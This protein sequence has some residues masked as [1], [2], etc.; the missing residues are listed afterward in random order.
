MKSAD[1]VP[2]L[3]VRPDA[4]KPVLRVDVF[5]TRQG[6]MDGL[7]DDPDNTKS[8]FWHH[9][10]TR[11]QGDAWLAKLPLSGT[12]KPI[13][14]YANVVYPLD[15]PVSGAGYYYRLYQ[16][17][18]FNL[19]SLMQMATP[20]E[21]KAAG[22][23]ATIPPSLLIE[24]FEGDWEK[25][26]FNYK[27]N[28]WTLNT[29]KLY[30]DPWKAPEGAR[31]AIEVLS[32]SPNKLIVGMDGHAAEINLAGGA[33]WQAASLTASDF[34]DASG[35]VMSDWSIIRDLRLAATD[36][37]PPVNIEARFETAA[38]PDRR[39]L[40]FAARPG[41][42]SI[43]EGEASFGKIGGGYGLTGTN[44]LVIPQPAHCRWT[45]GAISR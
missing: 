25:E 29:H 7:K 26:W 14:V 39:G 41:Q 10:A 2:S 5:Y 3:T 24:S 30:D 34:K 20:A 19:S 1:G 32:E 23:R 31:L 35:A 22:I 45:H 40:I 28:E 11:K 16:S 8:R 12:D 36:G 6:Q 33:A 9:A 17:D 37:G 4:S 42:E 13:W 44:D 43:K 18:R 27:L 21:L 38:W 15:P